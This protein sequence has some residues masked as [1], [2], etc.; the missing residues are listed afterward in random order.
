RRWRRDDQDG[1]FC[2]SVTPLIRPLILDL[3]CKAGGAAV[4]YARAGFDV[5]GVDIEPQPHYPFKFIQADVSALSGGIW[6]WLGTRPDAIHASPP[7]QK[8]TRFQQ[9][10]PRRVNRHPDLIG[11]T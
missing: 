2:R 10:Q 4:G 1:W 6:T 5:I 7:C 11:F 9:S 3:F 8:F